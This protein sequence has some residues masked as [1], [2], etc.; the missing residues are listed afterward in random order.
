CARDDA[1][2]K[3][4]LVRLQRRVRREQDQAAAYHVPITGEADSD[5]VDKRE[6]HR[7]RQ[8]DHQQRFGNLGRGTRLLHPRRPSG[9][10]AWSAERDRWRRHQNAPSSP[11]ALAIRFAENTRTA[12]NTP[13]SRP[14]A[15]LKP[16]S[17]PRMPRK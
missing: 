11:N 9:G 10:L 7:N 14:T 13:F 4:D 3:D 6:K 1:P 2:R 17:P 15:V 8:K 16:Q 12:A 5:H